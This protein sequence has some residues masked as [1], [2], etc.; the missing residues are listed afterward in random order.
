MLTVASL[1]SITAVAVVVIV[2]SAIL[3]AGAFEASHG[4][5]ETSARLYFDLAA[6][7]GN[8]QLIT[9]GAFGLFSGWCI[10]ARGA[11][12]K[13]CGWLGILAGVLGVAGSAMLGSEGTFALVSPLVILPTLAFLVYTLAL[14]VMTLRSPNANS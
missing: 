13:W 12:P 8:G 10:V 11:F 3:A 6:I 7:A 1:I 14:S 4:L 9:F 5:D 2:V